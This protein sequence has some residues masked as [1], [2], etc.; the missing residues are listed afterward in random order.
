MKA[1]FLRPQSADCYSLNAT[2]TTQGTRNTMEEGLVEHGRTR[3]R[4]SARFS[5]LLLIDYRKGPFDGGERVE[6]GGT[7]TF[8]EPFV[9][10]IF[11]FA[12]FSF[13]SRFKVYYM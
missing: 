10:V 11:P 9:G 2:T 13:L 7:F 12:S 3:S 1:G 8:H 6:R 5:P 4:R